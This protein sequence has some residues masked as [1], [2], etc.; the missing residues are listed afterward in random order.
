MSELKFKSNDSEPFSTEPI[1]SEGR[2]QLPTPF[3]SSL[4]EGKPALADLYVLDPL[5]GVLVLSH[6]NRCE[7]CGAGGVLLPIG[8]RTLCPSC[9]KARYGQKDQNG[10]WILDE[11]APPRDT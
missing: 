7:S 5:G 6:E 2:V 8:G 4:P 3:L 9:A 1:D 10:F 11:N